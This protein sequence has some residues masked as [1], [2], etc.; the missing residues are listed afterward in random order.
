[1]HLILWKPDAPGKR[2][3]GEGEVWVV[4]LEGSTLSEVRGEVKNLGKWNWEGRQH[5]ECKQI[6]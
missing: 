5:L 1:M 3:A 2:E 6:K 4:G